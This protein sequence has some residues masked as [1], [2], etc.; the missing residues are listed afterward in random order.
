M[1]D[2][3]E[4]IYEIGHEYNHA[5]KEYGGEKVELVPS[6]NSNDNWVAAIEKMILKN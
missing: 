6:L 2:C 4:T 1:A 5:F 3:L